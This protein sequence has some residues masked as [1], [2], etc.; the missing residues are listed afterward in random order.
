MA[1]NSNMYVFFNNATTA[2][3]LSFVRNT[4][5]K[6]LLVFQGSSKF[7]IIHIT[8]L[9]DSGGSGN[10]AG[11]FGEDGTVTGKKCPMGL[12]GTFC[13]VWILN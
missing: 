13:T 2:A 8:F 11:R 9:L 5:F 6:I 7:L 3:F 1:T 4:M 12:Y 10:Y